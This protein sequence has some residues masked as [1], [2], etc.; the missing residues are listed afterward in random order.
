MGLGIKKP[1]Y[2]IYAAG[3]QGT[4]HTSVIRGFLKKWAASAD[5]PRDAVYVYDFENKEAPQLILLDAG[6]GK[7]LKNKMDELVRVLA[8]KIPIVL[9]A[10]DFE[11]KANT[12]LNAAN[13]RKNKLLVELSTT[14]RGRGFQIKTSENGIE[15]IP[16]SGGEVLDEVAY[17][18]LSTEEK[19][20]LERQRNELE[21]HV[22]EFARQVRAIDS[23]SRDFLEEIKKEFVLEILEE[24]LVD[25]KKEFSASEDVLNYLD[26][27]SESVADSIDIFMAENAKPSQ[28]HEYDP[29]LGNYAPGD[30]DKFKKYR[31]NLFVDHSKTCLLYTSPSP[32]DK[33]QSRMPSSA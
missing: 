24:E 12:K 9:Q 26:Y 1:G 27:V 5:T 25:L 14:G 11:S 21:P 18:A 33:R 4:G 7:V 28:V 3:V 6:H 32:R 20:K 29:L 31:V 15:T 19:E 10:E 2:N 17:E 30:Q 13:N 23:E 8:R 16:M 22:L